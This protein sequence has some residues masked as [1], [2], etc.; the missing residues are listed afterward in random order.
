MDGYI[1]GIIIQ[2]KKK[3][4]PCMVYVSLYNVVEYII[5]VVKI[6]CYHPSMDAIKI[7]LHCLLFI[8]IFNEKSY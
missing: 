1:E 3:N 2:L 4:L 8:Y 7:G 6:V 5:V